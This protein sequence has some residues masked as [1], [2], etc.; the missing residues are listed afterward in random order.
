MTHLARP[1][2]LANGITERCEREMLA[3]GEVERLAGLVGR[4][5]RISG[6][7]IHGKK[8]G[9]ELGFPTANMRLPDGQSLMA[10]IYAV[11]F[12]DASGQQWDAVASF[13]RRPTVTSDGEPLL[14]SYV[15]GFEGDLYGQICSV[16]LVSF[17]R[18]ELKF[19]SVEDLVHRMRRDV[20]EARRILAR[21]R[22][23]HAP[24]MGPAR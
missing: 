6:E 14:E 2:G 7:V 20:L 15:F 17:I 21:T 16:D 4:P 12:I 24:A 19:R 22:S 5:Y 10:G 11:R 18:P 23:C 8:L 3:G 9:R 1:G 13:G